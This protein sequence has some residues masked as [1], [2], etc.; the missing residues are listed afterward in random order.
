M[1]KEAYYQKN[2]IKWFHSIGGTAITGVFPKGEADIQAG[3]PYKGKLLNV[4]VEVKTETDYARVMTGLEEKGGLYEIVDK[5]K[6]KDHEP[7]QVFK[8]NDVRKKGG[9]ALV[10]YSTAQVLDYLTQELM[11]D[12]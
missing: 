1:A 7:L 10:A 9:L 11:D 8:L 12:D 2:I 3:F 6:L 5:S 4:M